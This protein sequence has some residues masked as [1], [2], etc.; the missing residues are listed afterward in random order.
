[1]TKQYISKHYITKQH[2]T[3]QYITSQYMTKQYITKQYMMKQYIAVGA[4]SEPK[5]VTKQCFRECL[6]IACSLFLTRPHCSV[7]YC[8]AMYCSVMYY[9]LSDDKSWSRKE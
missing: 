5:T 9:D 4:H 6:L 3:K 7:M 2:I 8:S 1:M